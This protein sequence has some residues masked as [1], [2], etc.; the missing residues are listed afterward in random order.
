V[1][2][3]EGVAAIFADADLKFGGLYDRESKRKEEDILEGSKHGGVE[4]KA[5]VM[6]GRARA[7][8]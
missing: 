2:G 4:D 5:E 3:Y 1:V 7:L 8:L 6:S